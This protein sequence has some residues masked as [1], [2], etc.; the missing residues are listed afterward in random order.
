MHIQAPYLLFIGDATEPL[1]IKVANSIAHWRP[2]L[3]IGEHAMPGCTVTTSL[4]QLS[5]EEAVSKGAKTLILGF[6][7]SGGSID[8][9]WL[10]TILQAIEAGMDI[11]SGLHQRLDSFDCIRNHAK[12]YA[13]KLIDVRHP[14]GTF[15]TGTGDK[16]T[17]KRLLTV[18]TDCSSGKM[19]TA[20]SI[21]KEMSRRKMDVAFK[22]TGQCGIFIVGDGI[23]I[24]CV[25]ADF[26]AGAVEQLS[27]DAD[28]DHWDIIEGQGSLF[29]PAFAGV[30][31]GLLHGAQPDAMVL[32]HVENRD[33]MRSLTN[34][35]LPSIQQTLALN[36]TTASLTNPAAKFIGISLNTSSLSESAAAAVCSQYE[37]KFG[38]PTIDPLRSSL[39][40]GIAKLVDQL[41]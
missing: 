33:N 5:I 24:D 1:S 28:A 8:D 27:P 30:S 38:L 19:F 11:A 16:R 29:H 23:A 39:G 17:G 6:A 36:L 13:V 4:A 34:R 35:S 32:C 12:K 37:Q 9:N 15:F 3:V 40:S 18:G 22:A 25:V 14:T 41:Q 21:A 31:L 7:N 2:D 10:A 20:L 26:I